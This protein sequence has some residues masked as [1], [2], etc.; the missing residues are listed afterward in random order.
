MGHDV[1]W[2]ASN[3]SH[4]TKRFI[5]EGD[6]VE[7]WKGVRLRILKGLKYRRSVSFQRFR[8]QAHFARRFYAEALKESS[9][10][11]IVSPIP[12]LEAAEMATRFALERHIP[13][14]TDIRDE[15]PEDL[16]RLAPRP[17]RGLA[18]FVLRDYYRKARFVC[19]SVNAIF[20]ISERQLNYGISLSNRPRNEF[21]HVIPIG[22]SAETYSP[23]VI[24]TEIRKWRELG[25]SEG[26]FVC[27][28]FGTIGH[29]F[30]LE[31]VI[32]AAKVLE[33]KHP[34]QFVLC[35]DGS[36]LEHYRR[37][38]SNVRSV[39][40]PG[41]VK[42]PQISALMSISHLGLAPYAAEAETMSLPNKPFEYMA[43]GLPVVSS[44]RG[45]LESLLAKHGCGV[46]YQADSVEQL[47]AVLSLLLRSSQKRGQ[48][49]V[50]AK[51]TF[52]GNFSTTSNAEK[53]AR[54]LM[55]TLEKAD[56]TR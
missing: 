1:T 7:N 53:F 28:F 30:D 21:D 37:M 40:F 39:L 8:Y 27:C 23:A 29:F 22:Y 25:V 32:Q 52:E 38:A 36:R 11:I 43:A 56:T 2:W 41:W 17:F 51:A 31:T 54:N 6:R 50:S 15:W 3:F 26:S 34:I 45:E 12:T 14:V 42:G 49:G 9:P 10:D 4:S 13:I 33:K 18:R 19:S 20:G 5:C 47:C 35:G 24:E 44:I 46:T 55:K 48:M 16:A